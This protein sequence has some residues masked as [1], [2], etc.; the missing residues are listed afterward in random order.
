MNS[1][2]IWLVA[3]VLGLGAAPGTDSSMSV[4]SAVPE[5]ARAATESSRGVEQR[6]AERE[7]LPPCGMLDVTRHSPGTT[8]T[9]LSPPR[10]A[11]RCL[12]DSVGMGGAELVTLDLRRKGP[13]TH[14]FYRAT[15]DGR[16]E[17]WTQRTRSTP[18]Q[19]ASRWAYEE[20][21]PSADLRR[22]PCALDE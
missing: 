7:M 15:R 22:Q 18:G 19:L 10:K 2:L 12:D 1:I 20:C 21:T 11:W 14:T 8:G 4:E 13:T 6:F 5:P 16:L 17:I 3:A 9:Q